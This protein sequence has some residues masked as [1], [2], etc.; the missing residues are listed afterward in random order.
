[1]SSVNYCCYTKPHTESPLPS[2]NRSLSSGTLSA[3]MMLFTLV[4]GAA[5][6][7]CYVAHVGSQ[8][9]RYSLM[10]GAGFSFLSSIALLYCKQTKVA[11]ASPLPTDNGGETPEKT[12][13]AKARQQRALKPKVIPKNK[14][15]IAL[16][17]KLTSVAEFDLKQIDLC[18]LEEKFRFACHLVRHVPNTADAVH[19]ELGVTILKYMNDQFPH[20]LKSNVTTEDNFS[21]LH[22][23]IFTKAHKEVTAQLIF[24][25]LIRWKGGREENETPLKLIVD[26]LIAGE[27]NFGEEE[28]VREMIPYVSVDDINNEYARLAKIKTPTCNLIANL[29]IPEEAPCRSEAETLKLFMPSPQLGSA[30]TH[31]D[32]GDGL[33]L[34]LIAVKKG[35][36]VT[37]VS[38]ACKQALIDGPIAL[39]QVLHG[40]KLGVGVRLKDLHF[41]LQ[42]K[43][44]ARIAKDN[45]IFGSNI[46]P[47]TALRPG[48][49]EADL[50]NA[51]QQVEIFRQESE[52]TGHL[53]DP[54]GA[55][56]LETVLDLDWN[57]RQ[58]IV[59]KL[60]MDALLKARREGRSEY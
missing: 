43:E 12:P 49:T 14:K 2:K 34:P 7:Y 39:E 40:N 15:L 50:V 54:R 59:F 29:L 11:A 46:I 37:H 25:V 6:A 10:G 21:L 17:D 42:I 32:A 4:L 22:L 45:F 38:A 47:K 19:I 51:I 28:L 1:M 55:A 57:K 20:I 8:I 23:A 27:S 31:F 35:K 3:I 24:D 9:V 52:K 33:Y 26:R 5:I 36:N 48:K 60:G 18:T 30:P 58:M 56:L 13:P 44:K 16:F 53:P 41:A